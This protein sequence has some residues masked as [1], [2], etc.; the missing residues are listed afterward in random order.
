MKRLCSAACSSFTS[1]DS[2][3]TPS[4]KRA[5]FLRV[6]VGFRNAVTITTMNTMP[7]MAAARSWVSVSD[8]SAPWR[9]SFPLRLLVG[10]MRRSVRFELSG[11]FKTKA[12]SI[13][14]DT[15]ARSSTRRSQQQGS[16]TPRRQ[17]VLERHGRRHRA[18]WSVCHLHRPNY[19]AKGSSGRTRIQR[20][21]RAR[22]L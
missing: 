14:A 7:R 12:C 9:P 8:Q 3:L 5:N 16:V 4:C 13:C 11:R 18:S 20:V 17:S 21:R 10:L 2:R 19:R 1:S 22:P 15:G 6:T